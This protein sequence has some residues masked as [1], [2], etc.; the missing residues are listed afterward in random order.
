MNSLSCLHRIVVAAVLGAAA[1]SLQGPAAGFA[2][3]E[4]APAAEWRSARRDSARI[5]LPV[6][7]VTGR[8]AT[9]A[10]SGTTH[11]D[12]GAV[13]I[14][15]PTSLADLGPLLPSAHVAINSRG[16]TTLMIRGA[17]ERHVQTFLDGIPLNLP[18]DERT[19][20]GTIPIVGGVTLESRRGLSTLLD[21][22][23]VL[24]G[25]VSILAPTLA[26]DT[27]RTRTGLDV[28]QMGAWHLS[29]SHQRR[30]GDWTL[31]GAAD[32]HAR[33]AWRVPD[34]VPGGYPYDADEDRRY[35]SDQRQ[36]SVL[37]RAGRP[38]ARSGRLN[39][40]A[41]GWSSEQGTPPEMHLGDDARFWRYPQRR[42][43]LLG[44][45]L[46]RPLDT[47]GDWELASMAAV[48]LFRQEIDPRDPDRPDAYETGLD[49]TG[50]LQLGL[51]RWIHGGARVSLQG[52]ARYSH[53]RES[54]VLDGPELG[55]AQ[56]LTAWVAEA[57]ILPGPRWELR[58]G[59]GIDHSSTPESGDKARSYSFSDPALAVRLG[60]DLDTGGQLYASASRRSRFPSLRELYSGALGRF[61]ANPDLVP[62]RQTLYETGWSRS[63]DNWEVHAAGF[64]Q[65][66]D[67]GIEKVTVPGDPDR[68]FQRVNRT[69][70]RVPG[71]ETSGRWRPASTLEFGVQ[72]TVMSARVQR[73][74]QYD[75]PAEDR[76]D[77]LA[78]AEVG[79][80]PPTGPSIHL[81]TFVTGPRWSADVNDEADGLKRL[82]AGA[83]WN[84]GCGWIFE[85]GPAW[86]GGPRRYDLH[87]RL[88]NLF[89]QWIDYQV[90]LPA[91]G[92]RVTVGASAEF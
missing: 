14:R 25:R 87:V 27:R 10:V 73:A 76:P 90:G 63:G 82:P 47:A 75:Q 84:L 22:P 66:L 9:P 83:T 18:W 28:G 70:I 72:H 45:S 89:D 80:R 5:E 71:I 48:D 33:D 53:H 29:A 57:E 58:A 51:T 79:W 20:L 43:V 2:G 1:I 46:S 15:I 32:W 81:E 30:S 77:Y 4:P 39:V 36:G 12:A 85:K 61:V 37:L 49:R 42:R 62:E 56:W 65:T 34:G 50:H 86:F 17:P 60:C 68:R 59:A 55:Y 78:Q 3:E 31:L 54:L 19:D 69:S 64:V 23:G 38:I 67:D 88:E 74:G 40:L 44:A 8:A 52:N 26:K 13:E 41:T 92:R 21:G 16:E 35:N 24:A 6:L 7:T 11:I 91:P